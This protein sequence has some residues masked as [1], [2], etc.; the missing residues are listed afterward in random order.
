MNKESIYNLARRVRDKNVLIILSSSI[1]QED[2]SFEKD[3]NLYWFDAPSKEKSILFIQHKN[4]S[5][6]D[7]LFVP[8]LEKKYSPRRLPMKLNISSPSSFEKEENEILNKEESVVSKPIKK[9]VIK[10]VEKNGKKYR[11]K[12]PYD[13]FMELKKEK[14]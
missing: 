13:K 5:I 3:D 12:I 6:K 10:I 4:G 7:I 11:I 14:C 8:K 9:Y 2:F 1:Q